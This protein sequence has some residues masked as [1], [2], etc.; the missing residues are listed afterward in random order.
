MWQTIEYKAAA[1]EQFRKGDLLQRVIDDVQSEAANAAE[2]KAAASGNPLIL[3]QVKLASDLRKLEALYSQHQRSQ[4]RM[5]DRLK[6]L[7]SAQER[8]TKAEAEHAANLKKRDANTRIYTDDKGKERLR[9][10]LTANG[11]VLSVKDEKA[12]KTAFLDGVKSAQKGEER[13]LVGSY[14]GFEVYA[15]R[16]WRFTGMTNVEGFRF[17]LKGAGNQEFRPDNLTY[18]YDDTL[19]MSGWFQRLDNFLEKGLEQGFLNIK[20]NIEREIAEM[21]TVQAALGQGFPQKG[22]L[23][24]TRENHDAVMRELRRMQDEPNYVSSWEPKTAQTVEPQVAPAP[25]MRLC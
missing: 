14:R 1:I 2:M 25:A 16:H 23:A 8:L 5:K 4:H 20:A 21:A 7:G 3:M 10:E 11:R 13:A 24:L 9:I 6:W 18:S 17:A 12:I 22:E 19:S 15:L